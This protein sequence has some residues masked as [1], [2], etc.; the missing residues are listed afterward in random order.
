MT[1]TAKAGSSPNPVTIPNIHVAPLEYVFNPRVTVPFHL[2]HFA[3]IWTSS[4]PSASSVFALRSY[5]FALD[6]AVSPLE[7]VSTSQISLLSET[8]LKRPSSFGPISRL[9]I[10]QDQ[11]HIVS[12]FSLPHDAR[13][14][15]LPQPFSLSLRITDQALARCLIIPRPLLLS[16]PWLTASPTLTS[17][18]PP[19]RNETTPPPLI[20]PVHHGR[21][22]RATPADS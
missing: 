1:A 9:F 18:S 20:P 21:K 5:S 6:L 14:S 19:V 11:S 7:S 15:F 10:N 12:N 2:S 13:P 8:R 16:P 3:P 22:T 17:R 4:T